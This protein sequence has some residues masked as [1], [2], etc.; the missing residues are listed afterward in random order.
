MDQR[1][2]VLQADSSGQASIDAF[3]E[4]R[5]IVGDDDVLMSPAEFEASV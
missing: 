5:R 1:R 3:I 2:V 4:Y